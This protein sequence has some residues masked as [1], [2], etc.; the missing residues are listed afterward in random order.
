M[1]VCVCV[2][3]RFGPLSFK[4]NNSAT[5]A[6]ML[7]PSFMVITGC[8]NNDNRILLVELVVIFMV[9]FA[10]NKMVFRVMNDYQNGYGH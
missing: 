9:N 5:R 10:I 6:Q 1:C 2:C 8:D 7:I 4:C 3:V